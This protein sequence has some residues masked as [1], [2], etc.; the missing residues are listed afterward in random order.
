MLSPRPEV[1][2]L[3]EEQAMRA[4]K[5]EAVVVPPSSSNIG[6][7][8]KSFQIDVWEWHSSM[9]ISHWWREQV[10]CLYANPLMKSRIA[11]R[12]VI[13]SDP[14]FTIPAEFIVK[15]LDRIANLDNITVEG[16]VEKARW[17]DRFRKMAKQKL[18]P[19]EEE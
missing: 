18:K 4:G 14:V 17:L 8:S 16:I 6:V 1:I 15:Q 7:G 10:T 5:Y 12:S 11:R 13:R 2:C 19:F 3:G 9:E